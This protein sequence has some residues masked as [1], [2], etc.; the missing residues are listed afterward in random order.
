MEKQLYKTSLIKKLC[1]LLPTIRSQD[2]AIAIEFAITLPL[3]I[4]VFGGVF[5]MCS[6]LLVH[7]K[8]A[9]MNA[10]IGDVISRHEYTKTEIDSIL[11][12]AKVF[13]E[14]YDFNPAQIVVSHIQNSVHD[15]NP[16]N[17]LISWQVA[18]NGAT[19]KYG[20]ANTKPN[21]LPGGFT[22]INQERYIVTETTYTYTPLVFPFVISN[23]V[24]YFTNFLAPR[25]TDYDVLKN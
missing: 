19:S 16:A 2:G 13:L 25:L 8:L 6:L 3:L 4:T 15:N 10:V 20:T 7:S 18:Y 1:A 23:K 11:K 17:M 22:V 12:N 5:E 21:N 14:P 9:R 24:M